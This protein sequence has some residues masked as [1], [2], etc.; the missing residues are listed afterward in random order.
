MGSVNV[1]GTIDTKQE[2][3]SSNDDS[4]GANTPLATSKSLFSS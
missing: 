3:R 2:I 4:I 1:C